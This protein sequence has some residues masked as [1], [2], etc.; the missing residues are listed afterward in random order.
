MLESC[1][2]ADDISIPSFGET[3]LP[4]F[5]PLMVK[6]LSKPGVA[7]HRWSKESGTGAAARCLPPPVLILLHRTTPFK[8]GEKVRMAAG[9]R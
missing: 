2:N 3:S 4:I 6:G 7:L 9:A 1:P 5:R 8:K